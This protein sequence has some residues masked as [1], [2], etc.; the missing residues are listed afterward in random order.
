MKV[1]V[2]TSLVA[3]HVILN[4][5]GYEFILDK[6]IHKKFIKTLLL[7]NKAS[8][9]LK[10][11]QGEVCFVAKNDLKL[12]EKVGIHLHEAVMN[13]MSI[14]LAA[15][16]E[17]DIPIATA[18]QNYMSKYS[19]DDGILQM[20]TAKKHF[21]RFRLK[22]A[23]RK[24]IVSLSKKI[25]S[26]VLFCSNSDTIIVPL[27]FEQN[28]KHF[29]AML[30]DFD[31]IINTSCE[32]LNIDIENVLR[33]N[34]QSDIVYAKKALAA[35]LYWGCEMRERDIAAY[36]DVSRST[37]HYY[38]MYVCKNMYLF[39]NDFYKIFYTLINQH[40]DERKILIEDFETA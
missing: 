27:V 40:N 30:R 5:Y 3:A 6:S 37:A 32:V 35:M 33:K 29:I 21:Y 4:T 11:K 34:K 9:K 8:N 39:K 25:N 7:P 28:A 2:Y 14:Y 15:Q 16:T 12:S 22:E 17:M 13:E 10:D 20:D 26:N 38:I 18:I 19:L 23:K 1:K 31:G 36:F 24:Q